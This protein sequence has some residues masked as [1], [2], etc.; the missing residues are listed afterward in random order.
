[1]PFQVSGQERA[2]DTEVPVESLLHSLAISET[3]TKH[4]GLKAGSGGWRFS[5]SAGNVSSRFIQDKFSLNIVF[6]TQVLAQ[7]E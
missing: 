5:L 2:R 7:L 1:M 3:K 6:E 4:N